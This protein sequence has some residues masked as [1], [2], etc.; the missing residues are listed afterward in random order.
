MRVGLLELGRHLGFAYHHGVHTGRHRKEVLDGFLVLE[1]VERV[2]HHAA[3][4]AVKVVQ[5]ICDAFSGLFGVGHHRVDFVPVAGGQDDGLA[6]ARILEHALE[7]VADLVGSEREAF[8][9]LDSIELPAQRDHAEPAWHLYVVRVRDAARRDAFFDA[10]TAKGLGVQVHYPPVHL[11]PLFADL[12]YRPG[13][14][15]IA[16]D[17]AARALSLPVFPAMENADVDFVIDC[18]TSAA[19]SVL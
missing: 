16:E 19:R 17:Y 13:S 7:R 1:R 12:G 15:P 9:N 18:V 11:H 10:L 14:C 2:V 4:D 5:E 3:L 8:A 6:D